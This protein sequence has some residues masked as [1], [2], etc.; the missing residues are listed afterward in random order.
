MTKKGILLIFMLS[1]FISFSQDLISNV[2]DFFEF[3]LGHP[4]D[5]TLHYHTK[6]VIAPILAF[7]PSTS[8]QF[9]VGSKLLFKFKDASYET[10]TSNLPVAITYTLKRQFIIFAEYTFFTNN[11][12]YLI[13]GKAKFLNYPFV[14]YGIGNLTN[15]ESKLEISL[16][17]FSFAPLFLKRVYK[18]VFMGGGVR[19]SSIWNASLIEHEEGT[20]PTKLFV[21]NLN[22]LSSGVELATTLDS[23]DNVLNALHGHFVEV[24]HGVYG[25]FLGGDNQFSISKLNARTYVKL[26][27]HRLDVLAF[28]FYSRF[29]HGNV[30]TFDYSS[31]GGKELLRG[32]QERRFNANHAVFF[33]TEY[34]WQAFTRFGF[35][36]FTGAGDVFSNFKEDVS[37]QNMKFSLGTGLRIKIVKSENLNIRLDYGFGLGPSPDHNFYLGI[38]EAF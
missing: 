28:E 33:Q 25:K 11:E 8:L 14:Y 4:P 1:G 16:N 17:N 22:N 21:E 34:R 12:D 15:E 2:T 23:R 7:E 13:K 10:R 5:D 20:E 30:P 29:S 9:G 31:L 35:V 26:W 6:L 19:Y 3:E 27:D 38:A 18:K 32:F 36:F 24:T 37:L